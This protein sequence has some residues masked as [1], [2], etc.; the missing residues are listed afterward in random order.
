[1]R[2]ARVV[3]YIAGIWGVFVL[4]VEFMLDLVGRRDWRRSLIRISTMADRR[5]GSRR[6]LGDRTDTI[7]FARSCSSDLEKPGNAT[8]W[9]LYARAERCS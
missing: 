7:G 6:L 3:F 8:M 5:P 2:F 1:M 4:T 9:A